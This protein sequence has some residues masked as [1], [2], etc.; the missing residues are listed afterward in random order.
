MTRVFLVSYVFVGIKTL[1]DQIE[2]SFIVHLEFYLTFRMPP[3]NSTS[4]RHR[5]NTLY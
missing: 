5:R 4:L 2:K 1:D 3:I